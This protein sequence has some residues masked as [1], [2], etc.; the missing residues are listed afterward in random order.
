MSDGELLTY[1]QAQRRIPGFKGDRQ[2][3]RLRRIVEARERRIGKAIAVLVA[4]GGRKHARVTM[5]ALRQHL[6]Q[7]FPSKV[8]TL[9]RDMGG[10]LARIDGR[11]A[12]IAKQAIDE[13]V[14]PHIKKLYDRDETIAE[15]VRKLG[16]RIACALD[17]DEMDRAVACS[18]T[19]QPTG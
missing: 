18:D 11:M 13:Q 6:P 5:T 4:N 1:A 2:G 16:E 3:M 14:R 19:D 8:D 17:G 15:E 9:A 10:Y 12:L 7:L